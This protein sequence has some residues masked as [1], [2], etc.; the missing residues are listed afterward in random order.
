MARTPAGLEHVQLDN[1]TDGELRE[2]IEHARERL[3]RRIQ[4]RLQ[5]FRA[6]ARE[7]G[8]EVSLTKARIS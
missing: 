3:S 5:E 8:F 7:A 2:L 1:M 4:E 6:L